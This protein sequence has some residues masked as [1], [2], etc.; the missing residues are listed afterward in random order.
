MRLPY[1]DFLEPD[2]LQ[3][4]F[5]MMQRYGKKVRLL[6]G[7]TDIM[8]LMKLGLITPSYL[9]GLKN[10]PQLRG[11]KRQGQH[12]RIGAMTTLAEIATSGFI[13]KHLPAVHQ[14]ALAVAAP[15]IRNVATIGGNLFQDS[16]CIF[17][18]QS[19]TWRLER[20]ACLKAGGK[21]CLAVPG[22][23]KCFSVY[24]GDLAPALIAHDAKIRIEKKRG[25]PEEV[26]VQELFTGQGR[27][28]VQREAEEIATE[29]IVPIPGKKVSSTYQKLRLRSAMDYPLV[30]AA[31]FVS[32]A[33]KIIESA[34][35]VLSAAG[36]APVVV[37]INGIVVGR[38]SSEVDLDSVDQL[39][40]RNLPIVNN[41]FMPAWYRRKMLAVFAKR[42]MKAALERL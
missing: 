23:R 32:A 26:A 8:P 17:Y 15:P 40:P 38:R 39:I 10:L 14:A 25:K 29:V 18:N 35:I 4:M 19:G 27:N 2:T 41:A 22:S 31:A 6:A 12:V 37:P 11:I 16:R 20:Q 34:R 30:G 33:G 3:E 36:P 28:P 7:G 21:A 5:A 24:Q 1:F 9:L 42:S 13:E